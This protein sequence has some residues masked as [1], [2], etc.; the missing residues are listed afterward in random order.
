MEE[1]G[2]GGDAPQRRKGR[3]PSGTRITWDLPAHALAALADEAKPVQLDQLRFD[4]ALQQGQ[5]RTL[6]DGIVDARVASFRACPPVSVLG[7]ILV[8]PQDIS[9][10]SY[11]VLGGQH[12]VAAL[13]KLRKELLDQTARPPRWLCEVTAKVLHFGTVR[14]VCELWAGWHQHGQAAVAGMPLSRWCDAYLRQCPPDEPGAGL[15]MACPPP[16]QPTQPTTQAVDPSSS[17]A[18]PTASTSTYTVISLPQQVGAPGFVIYHP[19][20][21]MVLERMV[22]ATAVS[23]MRRFETTVCPCSPGVC[24]SFLHLRSK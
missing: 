18:H 15:Q 4:R 16:T 14:S 11:I 5:I 17:S 20:D 19:D 8:V 24:P 13:Q 12:T 3:K 1:G 9:G 22:T 10:R 2:I 21:S 7:D 23:G 6:D